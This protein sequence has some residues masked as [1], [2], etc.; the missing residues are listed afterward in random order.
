MNV[1]VA[2]VAVVTVAVTVVTT[3]NAAAVA[4]DIERSWIY[5]TLCSGSRGILRAQT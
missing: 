4:A 5:G 3:T 2:A 1:V